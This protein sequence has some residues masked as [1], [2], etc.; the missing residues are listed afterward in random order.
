[1][2]IGFCYP[3]TFNPI[4][5]LIKKIT[6]SNWSHCFIVL[7]QN[8]GDDAL[9]LESHMYGGIK[10]NLLSKYSNHNF[11][12][13]SLNGSGYSV[14][15]LKPYIGYVYGYTQLFGYVI[16]KIFR[17]KKN[18]I[19]WDIVCSELVLKFLK[20]GSLSNEFNDLEINSATPQDIYDIVVKS[21]N[22]KKI[23]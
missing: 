18:P 7:D 20:E 1:M 14:E 11:E 8:V 10:L 23:S 4:S 3:K 15:P 21:P 13:Y 17:L 2:K 9:I 22:F 6:K 5:W 16:A 12:L 19:T